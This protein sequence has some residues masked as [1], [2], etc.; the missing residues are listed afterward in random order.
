MTMGSQCPETSM[1]RDR[2]RRAR[3]GQPPRMKPWLT[4]WG[5]RQLWERQAGVR[6]RGFHLRGGASYH[7]AVLQKAHTGSSERQLRVGP[8]KKWKSR[9]SD[10][11]TRGQDRLKTSTEQLEAERHGAQT[12]AVE[13][14]LEMK[15]PPPKMGTFRRD[16]IWGTLNVRDLWKGPWSSEKHRSGLEKNS[17]LEI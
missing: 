3:S 1:C 15:V 13:A 6:A 10:G 12:D 2:K 7:R 16:E 14:T 9:G 8:G 17:S 4:W 5:R 11:E